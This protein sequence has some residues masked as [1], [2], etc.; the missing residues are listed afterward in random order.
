M[1]A[2]CQETVSVSETVGV[3]AEQVLTRKAGP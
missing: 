1:S 2:E 3:D